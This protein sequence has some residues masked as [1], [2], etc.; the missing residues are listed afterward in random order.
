[1]RDFVY[2]GGCAVLL[3]DSDGFSAGADAANESLVDPFGID[4]TGTL[5]NYSATATVTNP[6][7]SLIT[8]GPHGTIASFTQIVA[9]RLNQLG[10]Y[11]SSLATNQIGIALAEITPGRL[12]A[13]SGRVI[14]YTDSNTFFN[15]SPYGAFPASE[16]LFL[17]TIESCLSS[18]SISGEIR[19][20]SERPDVRRHRLDQRRAERQN[21]LRRA[22]LD[23]GPD[24]RNLHAHT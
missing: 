20:A 5:N 15:P 8:N 13:G 6:G 3:V 2:Q 18:R 10:P 16:K 22:L 21:R 9:G 11:A 19:D 23:C 14:V 7:V 24:L 4:V 17:N 1:M 12:Q